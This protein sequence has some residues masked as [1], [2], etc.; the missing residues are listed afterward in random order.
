ME[1]TKELLAAAPLFESLAEDELGVVADLV[2]PAS[3]E[4]GETLFQAG[5]EGTSLHVIREGVVEIFSVVSGVEKLFMTARR[6]HTVGLLSLFD[7]GTRPGS[8]R[9]EEATTAVTFS[10]ASLGELLVSS[11]N[12]GSKVLNNAGRILGRR[13]RML[14]DQYRD[15]VA[16][17]LEVTGL[18]SLDLERL[19]TERVQV[20]VETVRGEPSRGTLVRFESSAAGH[21]LYLANAEQ[22]IELIPYH[23]VVRIVVD[24]DDLGREPVE[25]S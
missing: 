13:V 16:W 24:R 2:S 22:E 23:A 17:N 7:G 18:A 14:T 21:E 3:W 10:Y 20:R 4:A 19:M 1:D 6:G 15:T 11:P 8:A 9:A 5:D 12:V 25:V